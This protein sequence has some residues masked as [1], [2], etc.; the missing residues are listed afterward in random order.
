[1]EWTWGRCCNLERYGQVYRSTYR[2]YVLCDNPSR[3]GSRNHENE[4][5]NRNCQKAKVGAWS[6]TPKKNLWWELRLGD[7]VF[8]F[9]FCSS[10]QILVWSVNT[11]AGRK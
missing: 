1:V 3:L 7:V 8:Y 2:D 5:K 6:L 11:K 4:M 10:C 9:R